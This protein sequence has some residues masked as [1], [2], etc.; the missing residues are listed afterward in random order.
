MTRGTQNTWQC[1]GLGEEHSFLLLCVNQEADPRLAVLQSMEGHRKIW[2]SSLAA[3]LRAEPNLFLKI[4]GCHWGTAH[5]HWEAQAE[6]THLLF[7]L[8]FSLISEVWNF[9]PLEVNRTTC[10]ILAAPWGQP[11][12]RGWGCEECK[13]PAC[14]SAPGWIQH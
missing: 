8:Q 3:F 11:G 1:Q 10:G 14:H 12:C 7:I 9:N 5:A 13:L 4:R 6:K 2:I